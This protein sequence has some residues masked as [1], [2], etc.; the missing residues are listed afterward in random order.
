MKVEDGYILVSLLYF[1]PLFPRSL[2]PLQIYIVTHALTLFHALIYITSSLPSLALSISPSFTFSFYLP[3]SLF[4]LLFFI[5]SSFLSLLSFRPLYAFPSSPSILSYSV[6]FFST[7]SF[8]NP[9][10][11]SSSDPPVDLINSSIALLLPFPPSRVR[12]I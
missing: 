9:T 1:F 2:I 3:L 7:P 11:F 10:V 8:L 12:L 6:L 5:L 4:A